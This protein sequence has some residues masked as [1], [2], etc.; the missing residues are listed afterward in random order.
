MKFNIYYGKGD[1]FSKQKLINSFDTIEVAEKF[2]F[3]YIKEHHPNSGYIRTTFISDN[4][5]QYYYGHYIKFYTIIKS[6][7]KIFRYLKMRNLSNMMK[8]W[9]FML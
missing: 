5:R 1:D 2:L 6:L 4:Q 9:L 7:D 8:Y 3:D